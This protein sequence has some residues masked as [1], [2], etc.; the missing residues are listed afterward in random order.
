MMHV[1][2]PDVASAIPVR[3]QKYAFLAPVWKVSYTLANGERECRLIVCVN[4]HA[5]LKM[6]KRVLG[7]DGCSEFVAGRYLGAKDPE[8]APPREHNPQ[9]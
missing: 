8:P 1:L 9:R 7:P 4:Q 5:V 2:E 6:C 3:E